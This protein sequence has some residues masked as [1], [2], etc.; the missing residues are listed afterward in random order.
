MRSLPTEW[1]RRRTAQHLIPLLCALLGSNACEGEAHANQEAALLVENVNIVDVEN[2]RA[3]P[4]FDVDEAW[5]TRL[6]VI[7]ADRQDHLSPRDVR[8]S[9]INPLGT[10]GWG[11]VNAAVNWQPNETWTID[12]GIDNLLDRRYRVHGSGIDATGRNIFVSARAS[13]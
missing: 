6:A 7:F 2:G 11:I 8:D 5:A 12:A 10:A 1:R 4:N 9:R 13:W 3:T